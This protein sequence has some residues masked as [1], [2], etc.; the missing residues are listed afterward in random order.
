MFTKE[1]K[2][3]KMP[4]KND[5][6]RIA[7]YGKGFSNMLHMAAPPMGSRQLVNGIYYQSSHGDST[8]IDIQ[9]DSIQSVDQ[10]AIPHEDSL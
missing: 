3:G 10:S 4:F 8:A 7:R 6:D 1:L 9:Q 2:S 5:K